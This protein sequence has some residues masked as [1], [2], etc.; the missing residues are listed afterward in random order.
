MSKKTKLFFDY[1]AIYKDVDL[2]EHVFI[3]TNG[4]CNRSCSFCRFG[5]VNV[6]KEPNMTK[7]VF[8]KVVEELASVDYSG[9]VSL[10]E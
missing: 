5:M 6:P 2:P 8:F 10:F 7:E 9:R 3:Q 4:Q 1:A